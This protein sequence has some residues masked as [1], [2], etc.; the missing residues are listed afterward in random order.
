MVLVLIVV[1][2]S[3]ASF[4]VRRPSLQI[5]H[6][7]GY[8]TPRH[9]DGYTSGQVEAIYERWRQKLGN[10]FADGFAKDAAATS[11]AP[12]VHIVHSRFMQEQANLTALAQ[13]RYALFRLVCLPTMVR[14]TT[15]DF[16]W[17]VKVDPN[18]DSVLLDQLIHDTI[19]YG[20]IYIVAS[21]NNFR[22]NRQFPGAWRGGAE[23][24]DLAKSRIY[25]GNQKRLEEAMVL[26]E[27]AIV[28][29]TRLDADDGLHFQY[30]EHLQQRARYAFGQGRRDS[31]QWMYWCSRR[32][33]EWHWVDPMRSPA[34]IE[35]SKLS[36]TVNQTMLLSSLEYGSLSGIR[37]ENMCVTPGTT[38]G[39]PVGTLDADVP[40]FAHDKLVVGLREMT[41]PEEGC[42]RNPP[43]SCL[44]FIENHVFEA[45]RSRTPTSAGMLNIH[46][47]DIVNPESW[48][49][50]AY[51]DMLHESF[52]LNRE[53]LKWMNHYLTVHL[54][55]IAEDNLVGQ[56]TTGHSCK[57]R[58]LKR[59]S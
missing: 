42:G 16:F 45:V 25:T 58:S 57:V 55:E 21:L 54:L 18:L 32:H 47:D 52:G 12:L 56:C 35:D 24:A 5:F 8:Y 30:L 3:L 14:Q 29:E 6:N 33:L 44:E 28:L 1:G 4:V 17:I 9:V 40:I 11:D 15:K 7:Q 49:H 41:S 43:S 48:A 13:A 27:K 39:F 59:S 31:V 37:H 51:W 34:M 10:Q 19:S 38:V 22:I 53:S 20:N 46:A 2:F 23:G 36:A 26:H 50:Y